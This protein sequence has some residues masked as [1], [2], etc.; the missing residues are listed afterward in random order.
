MSA[1][2]S[3]PNH[4]EAIEELLSE[5]AQDDANWTGDAP[6]VQFYWDVPQSEKQSMGI[7][8]PPNIYVWSPTSA[9]LP[10]FSADGDLFQREATVEVQVWSYDAI[11]VR[12]YHR[13]V[14]QLLSNYFADNTAQTEFVDIRP[15]NAS[16]FR[17]QKNPKTGEPYIMSVE[18]ELQALD[19]TQQLP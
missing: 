9:Q 7:D 13:D 2:A 8:L 17:E 12:E 10:Q 1:T 18:V 3:K 5:F 14:I 15:V 4:V 16:D 19:D 6:S 11:D